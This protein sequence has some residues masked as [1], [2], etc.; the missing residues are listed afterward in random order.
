MVQSNRQTLF[1]VAEAQAVSQ[2]A[3]RL[4]LDDDPVTDTQTANEI[5][6]ITQLETNV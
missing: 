2:S 1:S 4:R 6:V 5:L 3:A